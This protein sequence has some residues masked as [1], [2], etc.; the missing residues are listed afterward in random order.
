MTKTKLTEILHKR[1][2]QYT[3]VGRWGKYLRGVWEKEFT[4]AISSD[5]KKEKY[6]CTTFFMESIQLQ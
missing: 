2:I 6:I 4:E 1:N 3:E 5:E